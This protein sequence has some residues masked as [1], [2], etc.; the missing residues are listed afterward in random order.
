[1]L[2]LDL[3]LR[4]RGL[5]CKL[6]CWTKKLFLKNLALHSP[7]WYIDLSL[8]PLCRLLTC[9]T[10]PP[11]A[12]KRSL[13]IP[14]LY[15]NISRSLRESVETA[16]KHDLTGVN[17]K[18]LDRSETLSILFSVSFFFFF[19]LKLNFHLKRFSFLAKACFILCWNRLGFEGPSSGES[20][21]SN[22][23]LLQAVLPRDMAVALSSILTECGLSNS[24]WVSMLSVWTWKIRDET[25]MFWWKNKEVASPLL[26]KT[27][28]FKRIK[29]LKI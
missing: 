28:F 12:E 13:Q 27:H 29:F 19:L 23:S 21:K 10:N 22:R 20:G 3:A 8:I 2:L 4:Q 18:G 7:Q 26:K 11:L 1:M 25:L 9:S 24:A 5:C 16:G 17:F 6:Q 15:L 14:H